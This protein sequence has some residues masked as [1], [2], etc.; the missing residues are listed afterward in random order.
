MKLFNFSQWSNPTDFE[1]I[2]LVFETRNKQY[3]AY[4]IRTNYNYTLIRGFVFSAFLI[5]SLFLI[6]KLSSLFAKENIDIPSVLWDIT[7]F[8]SRPPE[9]KNETK[10]I[11]EKITV[12]TQKSVQSPLVQITDSVIKTDTSNLNKILITGIHNPKGD[13]TGQ[14]GPLVKGTSDSGDVAIYKDTI[15]QIVYGPTEMPEFIGGLKAMYEYMGENMKFPEYARSYDLSAKVR[16]GF[17][18]EKD[19]SISNIRI[20]A[21]SEKGYGFEEESIRVIKS[22][23]NWKPGLQNGKPVRV[24]YN[25][26]ICFRLM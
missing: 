2:E 22:M 15:E 14:A 21:C 24:Y 7:V 6:P 23:P 13:S 17:V 10:K 26:P 19:G 12:K 20:L 3:G 5:L 16:V 11:I 18:V 1:R 4:L 25:I 8:D 9:E